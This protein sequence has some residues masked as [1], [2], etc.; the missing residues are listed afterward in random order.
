[1]MFMMPTPPTNRL[2]PPMTIMSTFDRNWTRSA[3]SIN[4]N[5]TISVTS[6][7]WACSVSISRSIFAATVL[8]ID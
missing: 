6:C 8:T 1:M 2:S 5:G 7:F 3:C 4:S